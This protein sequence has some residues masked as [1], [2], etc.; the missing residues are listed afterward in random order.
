[1]VKKDNR[2]PR[3]SIAWSSSDA[4]TPLGGGIGSKTSSAFKPHK[5]K[6][7]GNTDEKREEKREKKLESIV[8]KSLAS[9]K[10]PRARTDIAE[11][12]KIAALASMDAHLSPKSPLSKSPKAAMSPLKP[13]AVL[14]PLHASK[15]AG[16]FIFLSS[17]LFPFGLLLESLC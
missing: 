3:S 10:R 5:A 16:V 6:T 15:I 11:E 7:G 1:V 14:S 8:A 13:T 17:I 12:A 4:T 2:N 9:R